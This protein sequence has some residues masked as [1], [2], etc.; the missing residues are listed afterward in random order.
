LNAF[1]ANPAKYTKPP[2][3]VFKNKSKDGDDE[4]SVLLSPPRVVSKAVANDGGGLE[5]DGL[6]AVA[7]A[8]NPRK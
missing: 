7:L 2:L 4:K 3:I 6:C 8:E 5:Y 1:K